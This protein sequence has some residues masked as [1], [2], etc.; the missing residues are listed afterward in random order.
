MPQRKSSPAA[1]HRNQTEPPADELR[2]LRRHIDLCIEVAQKY[3]KVAAF[4]IKRIVRRWPD[5]AGLARN[6]LWNFLM[7]AVGRMLDLERAAAEPVLEQAPA[8]VVGSGGAQP[9]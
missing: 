9:V 2:S 3:G 1:M 4:D 7:D 6:D 8:M 5:L